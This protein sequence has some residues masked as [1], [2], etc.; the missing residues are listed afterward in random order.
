MVIL[1][2]VGNSDA[3]VNAK[4]EI[5]VVVL[6][7]KLFVA[8]NVTDTCEICD[9]I[10]GRYEPQFESLSTSDVVCIEAHVNSKY[11]F[12]ITSCPGAKVIL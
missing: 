6:R 10:F 3:V 11:A 9:P 1:P 2:P 12:P 7:A 5:A 8:G 4:V